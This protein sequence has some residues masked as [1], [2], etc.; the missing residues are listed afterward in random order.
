MYRIIAG[1]GKNKTCLTREEAF[2]EAKK[3][4]SDI[5]FMI[6]D[7]EKNDVIAAVGQL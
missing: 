5:G 6:V 3:I 1:D 4:P 2:D 7:V